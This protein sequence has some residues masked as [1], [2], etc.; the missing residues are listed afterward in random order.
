MDGVLGPQTSAA[1]RAFQNASGLKETG[2]LDPETAK[3][4]GVEKRKESPSK[5]KEPSLPT[6]K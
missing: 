4:L 3:K 5:Q 1:I 6:D 2:R